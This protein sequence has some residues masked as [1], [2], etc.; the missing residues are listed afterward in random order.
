[1]AI[2]GSGSQNDP[3]LVASV[4]D[5][6]DA[7]TAVRA[8]SDAGTYYI[9]L[10]TSI[11]GNWTKFPVLDFDDATDKFFDFDG[12]STEST[13]LEIKNFVFD[14]GVLFGVN[15][16]VIRNTTLYNFYTDDD[17]NGFI[18]RIEFV[19]SSISCR[20]GSHKEILYD[21]IRTTR[22]AIWC[23]ADAFDKNGNVAYP[24]C[25]FEKNNNSDTL[26]CDESDFYLKVIDYNV[27]NYDV[28][29]IRGVGTISS[30]IDSRIQ[31][32]IT[33]ITPASMYKYPAIIEGVTPG[34]SVINFDMPAY[35]G[36]IT[37]GSGTHIIP[38]SIT[39][40]CI[41]NSDKIKETNY[42]SYTGD[43]VI[44]VTDTEMHSASQLT[45]KGF[46]VY[47]IS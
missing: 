44:P 38:P 42:A 1:M 30:M 33:N 39:S 7:I 31:G 4:A 34:N 2:S 16:D 19:D 23:H 47:D 15:G 10:T 13:P 40:K 21:S 8:K 26:V 20:V 17:S 28:P 43:N 9:K 24:L 46:P 11:D 12:G 27:N 25:T 41:I 36:T 29:L 37:S 14:D 32:E 45:T 6:S 35:S 18:S 5:I 22:C 3:Y